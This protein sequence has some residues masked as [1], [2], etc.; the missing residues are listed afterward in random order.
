MQ[1]YNEFEALSRYLTINFRFSETFF[2]FAPV[3]IIGHL[4]V[5]PEKYYQEVHCDAER[6]R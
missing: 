4:Y 5:I 3:I 6:R 2:N 1:I